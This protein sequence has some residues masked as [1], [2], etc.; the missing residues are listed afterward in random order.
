MKN[1][2]L[3]GSMV[4]LLAGCT[5]IEIRTAETIN[6][7]KEKVWSALID[8]ENYPVWNPYH[9]SVEGAFREGADLEVRIERP[10]GK[11]V[12]IPPHIIRIRENEEL[13]WGGGIKPLFYGEHT[14]LLRDGPNGSTLL[15]HNED[16]DG[17]FVG[18]ADLPPEVLTEGYN[19]MNLALKDY[20]EKRE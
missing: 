3:F 13:T 5:S 16:F 9:V 2:A 19:R 4:V 1:L 14:F 6:A 17:I 7:P 20:L 18:F 15:T 8:F 10:D 11:K 12:E